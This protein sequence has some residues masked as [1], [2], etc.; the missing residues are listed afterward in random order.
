MGTADDVTDSEPGPETSLLFNPHEGSTNKTPTDSFHF[1]Y[2]IYFTFGVG[3]LLPW[4]SFIT[5]VDYFSYLYPSTA[6]DRIFAVVYMLVLVV[7]FI[8]I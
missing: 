2:I 4:N 1:A 8:I 3:F 6:V 5:A 7:L